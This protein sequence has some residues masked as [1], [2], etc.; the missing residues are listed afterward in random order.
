ML[1]KNRAWGEARHRDT[2]RA[3]E[4]DIDEVRERERERERDH[5]SL[6]AP[7][8][9]LSP[10]PQTFNVAPSDLIFTYT[11]TLSKQTMRL[12]SRICLFNRFMYKI[13]VQ[14]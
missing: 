6:L 3:T 4:R 14:V 11:S 9:T 12:K 10:G 13:N 8:K 7:C 1:V 5:T 2:T